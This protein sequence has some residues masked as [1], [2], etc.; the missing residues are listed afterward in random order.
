MRLLESSVLECVFKETVVLQTTGSP[1]GV[2]LT[3]HTVY[4][5]SACSKKQSVSVK[6][7]AFYCVALSVYCLLKL[8]L[9]GLLSEV[10]KGTCLEK[11]SVHFSIFFIS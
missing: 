4:P 6:G 9:S 1:L 7:G 2:T 8:R 3:L 5:Y 11:L 10:V